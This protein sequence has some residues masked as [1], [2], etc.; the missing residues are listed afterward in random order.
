MRDPGV[1]QGAVLGR[2]GDPQ[3]L[4]ERAQI[5]A[6]GAGEQHRSHVV[7]IQG[8]V[9]AEQPLLAQEADIEL[10]VMSQDRQVGDEVF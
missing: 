10:D 9:V 6:P 5:V 4:T 3:V 7:G 2:E 1:F 8:F